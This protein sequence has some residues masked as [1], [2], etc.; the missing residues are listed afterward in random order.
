MN[1]CI[2]ES[3]ESLSKRILYA[4]QAAYP[5]FVPV[6]CGADETSQRDMH[7]FMEK[8]LITIYEKP[9]MF[10]FQS[11]PDG[12][13]EQWEMANTKPEL[14]KEMEKIENRFISIVLGL[15]KIGCIGEIVPQGMI[16][17]KESKAITKNTLH[18]LTL[19]GVECTTEKNHFI[20]QVPKYPTLFSAWKTYAEADC[21]TAT[22]VDR[23]I[24]FIYGKYYGRVYSAVDFFG[25]LFGDTSELEKLENFYLENGYSCMN[26]LLNGK[27]RY[28]CTKWS[29]EYDNG[30]K[31]FMSICYEW[32][33]QYPILLQFHL[34]SFQLMLDK[35]YD[36]FDQDLQQFVFTRLKNCDSCGYCI[37]TDKSGKRQKICRIM[38][39]GDISE[40]KCP[41]FPNFT[42]NFCK[43]RDMQYM[44]K[45]FQYAEAV[46]L[47]LK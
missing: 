40:Q 6:N 34:P 28:A 41:L 15:I 13:F 31:A 30:Q 8:A 44:K 33:R 3:F 25:K 24:S 35:H 19:L 23:A 1:Y 12:Y 39:C 20:L 4:Y 22:K 29:K 2:S 32:K 46:T 47:Y 16:V 27:T 18:I 36:S 26:S 11:I 7:A 38:T 43:P 5:R 10:G 9:D 17:L 42:F 21:E 45:L 14:M 37:Q